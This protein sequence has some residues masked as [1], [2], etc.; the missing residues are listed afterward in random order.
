MIQTFILETE[1]GVSLRAAGWQMGHTTKAEKWNR[2]SRGG[3][4]EDQPNCCKVVWFKHLG[5]TNLT[6]KAEG[7]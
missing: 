6:S 1:T 4:R 2:P 7:V 3:R 5:L